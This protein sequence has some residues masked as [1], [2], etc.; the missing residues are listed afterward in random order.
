M[1]VSFDVEVSQE[2]EECE[3]KEADE[4]NDEDVSRGVRRL[5][6]TYQSSVNKVLS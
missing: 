3:N 4:E 5:S 1:S 6:H 2:E